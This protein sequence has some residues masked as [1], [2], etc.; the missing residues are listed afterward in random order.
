MS[1]EALLTHFEQITEA[2]DAVPR[3]RKLVL[4]LAVRG[5][6]TEI[7][8]QGSA[9]AVRQ[10]VL[11]TCN[12]SNERSGSAEWPVE[13]PCRWQWS[14]LAAICTQVTDGEHATPPR[15]PDHEVPL[16][17]AKNVRDG[18]MDF[19]N[20]D[21]VA[22][23]TAKK[24]WQRCRPEVG[25]ILMVCVG[26]TTGRLC[27]LKEPKDMVL[28][29]SV[30]LLRPSGSI[31]SEFLSVCLRSPMC[32]AQIWSKVKVAAQPCLYINRIKSLSIP[33]PPPDEQQRVVAK[34]D[35][36]MALCDELE[37]AQAKRERRRDRLVAA[38]LHGLNN[39]EASGAAGVGLSFAE[40]ARFYFN[41]LPRLTTRPEHIQ[42]L[43]Q[44]ILNLAVRGRLVPQDSS[45][46][47][48]SA[49]MT[50][51]ETE[52]CKLLR[53]GDIRMRNLVRMP[54]DTVNPYPSP[55]QW[56][57][58]YLDSL[59][60]DSDSGW[61]P[62]CEAFPRSGDNWGV[63]KVSA[64]SWEEFKPEENKQ[65]L[66]GIV[67]REEARI[68]VG[69]FLISRANTSELVAKC[70]VVRV[71]PVNLMMSDKIVRL[72]L[73]AQL[74]KDF[75]RFVN[76][77]ADYA[78]AYYAEEA[79]GT[80]LSMKNVSRETIYRLLVPLPPLA[81]QHRI[82]AKVDELIALCDEL[83]SHLNESTSTRRALLEA[84]LQQS[85]GTAA[86]AVATS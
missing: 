46:G 37:A 57:W 47:P 82:V 44:T 62:Q 72:R 34:V 4:D 68:R 43:R 86:S 8:F 48:A 54:I 15:V 21:W 77:H 28:V 13:L 70:V 53:G 64:V 10:R 60:L 3:V 71:N 78:R 74:N 65:M 31:S 66:R 51:I 81:E 2:P 11:T 83:E 84:T 12:G 42:Q 79:S 36:L 16:I 67:A 9:Q 56:A 52:R 32:Q 5:R 6:L 59:V 17:T 50:Q 39:G 61:S 19:M 25:D 20:T 26:A 73:P 40:T 85:L 1:P 14:N 80:S 63:V 23:D 76:N 49:L 33:L 18:F 29:R 30:A 69:D 75:L 35:E 58:V 41:H 27:I 7:E 22:R 45:E 24:A 55:P 38:T